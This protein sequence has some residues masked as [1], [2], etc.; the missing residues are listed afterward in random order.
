MEYIKDSDELKKF[1]E[2]TKHYCR[3]MEEYDGDSTEYNE[4]R[5]DENGKYYSVPMCVSSGMYSKPKITFHNRNF[6]RDGPLVVNIH[7][8]KPYEYTV[9]GWENV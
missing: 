7:E 9:I 8:V 1:L 4:I 3:D 2:S 5:S 6:K